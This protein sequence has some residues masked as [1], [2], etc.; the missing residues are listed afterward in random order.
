MGDDA[1]ARR[2]PIQMPSH[3][4]VT[5]EQLRSMSSEDFKELA[6]YVAGDRPF[7][8]EV[9]DA[10]KGSAYGA[11]TAVID[12]FEEKEV[13]SFVDGSP[14]LYHKGSGAV[15]RGVDAIVGVLRGA[16]GGGGGVIA[17]AEEV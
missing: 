1:D 7:T 16:G 10:L 14:I 5:P 9:L 8:Q 4:T 2:P 12:V 6:L 13:P 17:S 11:D 3:P 15:H